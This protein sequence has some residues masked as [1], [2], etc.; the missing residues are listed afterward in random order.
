MAEVYAQDVFQG[1]ILQGNLK[2]ALA[3]LKKFPE[4]AVLYD[5]YEALFT[6]EPAGSGAEDA[7]VNA[8]LASY[9]KY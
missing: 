7:Q 4:K 2:A 9:P 8:I 3:Y 5:R 6:E 1:C